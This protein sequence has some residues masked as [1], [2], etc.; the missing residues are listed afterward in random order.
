MLI[1]GQFRRCEQ[2]VH[3]GF[4]VGSPKRQSARALRRYRANL[5]RKEPRAR[6]SPSDHQK[7]RATFAP[8]CAL[9]RIMRAVDDGALVPFLKTSGPFDRRKSAH[10]RFFAKLD[11][12]GLNRSDCQCGILFLVFATQSYWRPVVS[13]IYE[14]H[15][16]TAF[17]SSRANDFFGF[18]V[19]AAR[20]QPGLLV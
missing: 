7:L 17:S 15:W 5:C 10:N 3:C 8:E 9:R 20:K 13:F 2:P 11:V 14:L 6:A 19:A 1:L 16:R 12:R 4:S 18:A